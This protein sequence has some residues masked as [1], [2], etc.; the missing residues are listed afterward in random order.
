M[1]QQCHYL[2]DSCV[3]PSGPQCAGEEQVPSH[4]GAGL[5]PTPL[6][7][8]PNGQVPQARPISSFPEWQCEWES[9]FIHST[10]IHTYTHIVRAYMNMYTANTGNVGAYVQSHLQ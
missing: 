10:Y 6:W 9:V 3:L 1:L 7:A 4:E 8:V 5:R 2:R